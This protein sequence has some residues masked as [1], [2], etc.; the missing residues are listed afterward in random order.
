MAYTYKKNIANRNNYGAKRSTSK[1]K[2]IVIHF[3]AND[4]DR[5]ENNGKYFANNIVRASAH[6]FVDS[7]SVTQSVPDNYVAWSVGGSRYSNYKETGGATYYNK[8]TNTNSISI[9]LCDDVKN[10]KIYP[11]AKTIANAIEL[12]EKLM[13]QY[14][15]PKSRVIRHFDVNGKLCPA[16][17]SGT[18]AKNKKW[19][20]EF[21]DK[22]NLDKS[23]KKSTVKKST[24]Y[25]VE[26][27]TTPLM[28]RAGA[29]ADYKV[30]T[31]V[32][33]GEVYTI[34]ATKKV[35]M[36]T[37]GKLKSGVGWIN[38]KYSKKV[39]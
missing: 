34:I 4:G 11:S 37:W 13:K 35:G 25:T 14:N 10:G 3:T 16:Y 9:E 22:L 7:D 15:V 29:G 38:L 19:E 39:K 1:I 18:K 30:V 17:W 32:K 36:S 6:Y 12:T 23:A 8:V 33:K 20:T 5:D 28:V 27:T 2:Y 31:S 24:P 26:I 21:W